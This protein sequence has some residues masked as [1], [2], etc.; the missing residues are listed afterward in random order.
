MEAPIRLRYLVLVCIVSALVIFTCYS[1][2]GV[3]RTSQQ[4]NQFVKSEIF[5][6]FYQAEE[7]HLKLLLNLS[8]Y[9]NQHRLVSS[10]EVI[11]QFDIVWA[12]WASLDNLTQ[13]HSL[14]IAQLPLLKSAADRLGNVLRTAEKRVLDLEQ[15]SPL[16]LS[17][18]QQLLTPVKTSL[19]DA[20]V[21]LINVD[22]QQRAERRSE[23]TRLTQQTLLALFLAL[24]VVVC[25]CLLLFKEMRQGQKLN[26]ELEDRVTERTRELVEMN[27][28]LVEARKRAES[29]DQAKTEFLSNVSH[30]L[31]TPLNAVL[32]MGRLLLRSTLNARQ[33]SQ[34]GTI[35]D[36]GE[37]L[38]K[39]ITEMLDYAEIEAGRLKTVLRPFAV[40]QLLESIEHAYREPAEAKALKLHCLQE[41][42]IPQRLMG[43][44]CLIEKI[45]MH[46]SDNAVKYT[47]EGEI[48][49]SV[50][51]VSEN[52]DPGVIVLAFSVRDTGV[53]MSADIQSKV[54]HLF[55]Q[56]D[57]SITRK[58]EGTGLGLAL[59][60]K[61]VALMG[62]SL[63]CDSVAGEGSEFRFSLP[64]QVC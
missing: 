25:I 39:K 34:A 4:L 31:R 53:G 35:V 21:T 49:V 57:G 26:D 10:D 60:Q 2:Y 51:V 47:N 20:T 6:M 56:G 1:G 63:I 23:L 24:L 18:L 48:T 61:M 15:L 64:C 45:L 17:S 38:L 62:G 40:T 16:E 52:E 13:N 55:T 9:Q 29:A 28:D 44:V 12:F 33:Q 46:L 59:S 7:S 43:D 36:S 54:F 5:W 8:Q 50:R 30:E 3:Y 41:G 58:V 14:E 19:R 42:A 27:E 22:N 37:E 32:G 11:D